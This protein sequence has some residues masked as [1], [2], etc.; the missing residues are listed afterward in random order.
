MGSQREVLKPF[1]VIVSSI[2]DQANYEVGLS[3]TG[4]YSAGIYCNYIAVQDISNNATG[5]SLASYFTVAPSAMQF[6]YTSSPQGYSSNNINVSA[7]QASDALG[8][9]RGGGSVVAGA[10][11]IAVLSLPDAS[12]CKSVTIRNDLGFA[13]AFAL[14]YGVVSLSNP[15]RDGTMDKGT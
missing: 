2:A 3:G 1:S 7:L 6:G 8:F 10:G 14:T 12:R 15:L 5:G 13:A 4:L 11:S 9:A